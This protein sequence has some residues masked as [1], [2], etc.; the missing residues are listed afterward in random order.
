MLFRS[1]TI[2]KLGESVALM[3]RLA[4]DSQGN[5]MLV[6]A[7]GDDA[8]SLV[9]HRYRGETGTWSDI[10]A[11]PDA[12]FTDAEFRGSGHLPFGFAG[13]GLGGVMFRSGRAGAQT[14]KLASFF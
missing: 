7:V 9:Y 1:A 8:I 6:W 4:V 5:L 2:W 14:L 12:T 11:I 10:R 13:N 3:P